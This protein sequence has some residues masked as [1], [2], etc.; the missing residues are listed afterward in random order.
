MAGTAHQSHV[1]PH[2]E[3]NTIV[4]IGPIVDEPTLA[5]KRYV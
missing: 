4:A 5:T 1:L 2:C 3:N